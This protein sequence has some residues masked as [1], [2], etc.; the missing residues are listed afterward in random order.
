MQQNNINDEF[1]DNSRDVPI[2]TAPDADVD[3]EFNQ[4]NNKNEE[5]VNDIEKVSSS[6]S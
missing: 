5:E 4:T 3:S 6:S 2:A 1:L